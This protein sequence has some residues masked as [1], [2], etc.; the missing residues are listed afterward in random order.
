MLTRI[1]NTYEVQNVSSLTEDEVKE[2]LERRD[3][4]TICRESIEKKND[5]L[6]D[7]SNIINYNSNLN[8]L[9]V[10]RTYFKIFLSFIIILYMGIKQRPVFYLAQKPLILLLVISI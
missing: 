6:S 10:N 1:H 5:K 7:L 3:R 9:S 4:T 8:H 2:G